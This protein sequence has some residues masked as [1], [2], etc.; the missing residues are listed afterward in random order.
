MLLPRADAN[1]DFVDL[2]LP[3]G[4]MRR[5]RTMQESLT[6][7]R[8]RFCQQF[9]HNCSQEMDEQWLAQQEAAETKRIHELF[10]TCTFDELTDYQE[11]NRTDTVAVIERVRKRAQE[12]RARMPNRAAF[13][14]DTSAR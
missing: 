1:T 3:G 5:K 6:Q 9:L 12:R 4:S 8:M 10:T 2:P 14:A 7:V 13:D 11:R